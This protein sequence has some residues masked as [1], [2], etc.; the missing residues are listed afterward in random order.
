[1]V[2]LQAATNMHPVAMAQVCAAPNKPF[3]KDKTCAVCAGTA[4]SHHLIS[5][6]ITIPVLVVVSRPFLNLVPVMT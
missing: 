6:T 4:Y 5:T 1:M 3:C 2:T